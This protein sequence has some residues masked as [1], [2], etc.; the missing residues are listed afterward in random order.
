MILNSSL[1]GRRRESGLGSIINK[2]VGCDIFSW[3]EVRDAESNRWTV[4]RSA[5]PAD[6]FEKKHYSINFVSSPFRHRQYGLFGFLAG[7][8][9][10]GWCEPLDSPRGLP[11]DPDRPGGC[12]VIDELET[13]EDLHILGTDALDHEFHSH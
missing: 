8:R 10:D 5:F 9:N 7:V 11:D 13:V 1:W 6:D 12:T 3:V 4:V 2:A